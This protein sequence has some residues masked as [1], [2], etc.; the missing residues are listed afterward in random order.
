M[1]GLPGPLGTLIDLLA[2]LLGFGA[3]VFIHELGHFLAARWA[4]IRVLTFAVGF[5]PALVSFR[6]GIG[7]RRG[8]S[9]E[10]YRR[11]QVEDGA[12]GADAPG[13]RG[14]AVSPTEYRLSAL[15]FGGY[16]QMLGQDDLD[17][18]SVSQASDSYQNAPVWK[19]M[20]VISAGVVMNI[21]LAA[22]L[23]VFVFMAGLLVQPPVVGEVLE[24][25]P[26]AL[27]EPIGDAE[28]GLRPG[29]RI[30]SLDGHEPNRFDSVALK[31][32]MAEKGATLPVTVE[33]GGT[34]LTYSV[35]P[36]K[37][38]ATGLL[39]IGVVP[40]RSNRLATP[41]KADRVA[42]NA[43]LARAGLGG[44]EAGDAIVAIDGVPTPSHYEIHTAFE[45]SG[46][47]ALTLDIER[48]GERL[49]VVAEPGA[50]MQLALAEIAE[51]ESIAYEHLL[52]MTPVLR[53][54][55]FGDAKQGL[56]P[57]D[58]IA[59]VGS[60]EFPGEPA[61]IREIRANASRTIELEVLRD[62]GAGSLEIVP[63]EATVSRDGRVGFTPATTA[64]R[65]ALL[66]FPPGTLVPL[67]EG[68]ETVT[69][70]ALDWVSRAGVR[71][72]SINSEPVDDFR[73][74]RGAIAAAARA[75]EP[76]GPVTLLVGYALPRSPAAAPT[77]AEWTITEAQ[78]QSVLALGWESPIPAYLFEPAQ[79]LLKAEGP[80][81]AIGLGLDETRRV[82]ASVY[83]TFLR[84]TQGSLAVEH[85][86]GPV[87]IAHIGTVIADRGLIWI[88]FFLAMISVNLAV[89]NFLP[90]PIV[91]GGQFLMLLYEGLRGKPVPIAVQS[92][93]MTAGLVLIASVFLIVT[94]NDIRALIGV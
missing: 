33:R 24:G 80:A 65:S 79:T 83:V 37:G 66:S 2:V 40:R 93:I 76:G 41:T 49:S 11:R 18:T 50:S 70:P 89:V 63:I 27:A 90:L 71:V 58:V 85:I 42:F 67:G 54:A 78:A 68:E 81:D 92:A 86:K 4:G 25:S 84:L 34:L 77:T 10:E 13:G 57:G 87:G 32:A 64:D 3:I 23:F 6:R 29:D 88:L 47:E 69:P 56:E 19:R 21:I 59:R 17:P 82:M 16:V 60:L 43:L 62:N 91:D 7:L 28:P 20:V 55:D 46:G 30:V 45:N 31:V 9:A 44:L 22:V 53:V 39:E 74:M 14:P 5:G 1:L 51:G 72:R 12:A 35:T 75:A 38:E 26:A 36:E 48:G 61:G 94:F 73:S 8:S 15:P 52:G